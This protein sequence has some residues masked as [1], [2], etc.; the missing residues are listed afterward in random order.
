[1][2][3]LAR[4]KDK[5]PK[6]FIYIF[7]IVFLKTQWICLNKLIKGKKNTKIFLLF[8]IKGMQDK[9]LSMMDKQIKWSTSGPL[10]SIVTF[11]IKKN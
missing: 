6:A 7:Y 2:H 10:L 1:M 11:I 9:V 3:F 4:E 5:Y 8:Y